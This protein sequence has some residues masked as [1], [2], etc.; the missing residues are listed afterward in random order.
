MTFHSKESTFS[1]DTCP[2]TIECDDRE[3]KE[4]WEFAKDKGWRGYVGPDKKF[5]HSCPV[6]VVDFAKSKR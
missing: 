4:A 2:E 5:A 3:F 1:C 6:C